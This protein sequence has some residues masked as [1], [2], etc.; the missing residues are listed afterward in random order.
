M[1]SDLTFQTTSPVDLSTML[2]TNR[3]RNRSRRFDP[4]VARSDEHFWNPADP[5]YINFDE[6]ALTSV[7]LLPFDFVIES[8]TAIWDKLKEAQRLAFTNDYARWIVSNLLHCEQ[9][10]LSLAAGLCQILVDPSSQE[11]AANQ[12]REEARHV[13]AFTRYAESR[14]DGQIFAVTEPVDTLL[15]HLVHTPEINRKILGSQLLVEGLALGMFSTIQRVTLDPLLQRLCQLVITDESFHYQFGKVWAQETI[16]NLTESERD[17]VEDW[18]AE[19]FHVFFSNL[20]SPDL[21]QPLYDRYGLDLHWVRG[22][23][24]EAISTTGSKI[25]MQRYARPARLVINTLVDAGIITDRTRSTYSPWIDMVSI[26]DIE[27]ETTQI[28]NMVVSKLKQ[29]NTEKNIC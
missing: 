20:V 1:G 21:K 2:E 17:A 9:G 5:D 29:I 22:A 3:Y 13:N 25:I 19:W 14:F 10:A 26:E 11:Y 16:P 28:A 6:K 8:G 18:A 15:T 24:E 23:I 7:P 4:I 27:A 12:A